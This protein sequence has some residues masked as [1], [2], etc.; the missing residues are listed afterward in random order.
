M[1][2]KSK[3]GSGVLLQRGQDFLLLTVQHLFRSDAQWSFE[4]GITHNRESLNISIRDLRA[5]KKRDL[6][7]GAMQEIDLAW[8]WLRRTDMVEGL[9]SLPDPKPKMILPVYD[10]PL[11]T[12]VM[13]DEQY[14]YAANNRIKWN[15]QS[16]ELMRE[17]SF[18]VGMTLRSRHESDGTVEFELAR[19]HQGN[20][21][22]NG[23][24]GAPIADRSGRIVA[25][26]VGSA[27][28]N[29]IIGVEL[30]QFSALFDLDPPQS[31]PSASAA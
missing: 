8:G 27:P 11:D 28:G 3:L 1:P 24:S 19:D 26:L 2:R 30:S 7:S 9:Q 15:P 22:Y 31:P 17:P 4:T 20:E 25:L 21:Y 10:G 5:L 18:E 6:K 29:V 12:A 13:E 14:G 23:A 16:R